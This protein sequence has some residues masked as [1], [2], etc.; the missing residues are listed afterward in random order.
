MGTRNS[1]DDAYNFLK[2]EPVKKMGLGYETNGQTVQK[3]TPYDWGA[4]TDHALWLGLLPFNFGS[5][6]D[7]KTL[8]SF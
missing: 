2:G 5:K 4:T 7:F 8:K 6:V 3:Q 1:Q